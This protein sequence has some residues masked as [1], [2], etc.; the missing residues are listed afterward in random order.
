MC[1]ITFGLAFDFDF[2]TQIS[3]SKILSGTSLARLTTSRRSTSFKASSSS[4][5][6]NIS[7]ATENDSAEDGQQVII[8]HADIFFQVNLL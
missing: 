6:A 7:L 4:S 1:R 5:A 3:F 2:V 8:K